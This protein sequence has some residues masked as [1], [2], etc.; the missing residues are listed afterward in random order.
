MENVGGV[1]VWSWLDGITDSM[2]MSLSKLQELVMDKEARRAAVHGAAKS[3]TQLTDWT[4]W[5]MIVCDKSLSVRVTNYPLQYSRLENPMDWGA[6]WATAHGVAKSRTWLH[7][8]TSLHFCD[9]S[10][11]SL[12]LRLSSGEGAYGTW[13]PFGCLQVNESSVNLSLRL[14]F[15]NCMQL[16]IIS[17]PEWH[18]L[19]QYVLNSNR[20]IFY[21]PSR[22]IQSFCLFLFSLL[23]P[24]GELWE[25]H[26]ASS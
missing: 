9:K 26:W 21:Y 25:L 4:D 12:E 5:L 18:I 20:H 11:S 16:K 7:H 17:T 10:Q 15:S 3:K 14:M 23:Y 22:S 2:D 8:F 6:W 1:I 13:V 19:G 24:Y